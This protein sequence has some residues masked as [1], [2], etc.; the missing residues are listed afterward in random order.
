M[1]EAHVV[2]LGVSTTAI[3]YATAMHLLLKSYIYIHGFIHHLSC[4]ACCWS[5][6]LGNGASPPHLTAG[7]DLFLYSP[8]LAFP[9]PVALCATAPLMISARPT[10][11]IR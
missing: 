11:K 6:A 3:L 7:F 10:D 5:H 2:L 4:D 8:S 9:R 1:A